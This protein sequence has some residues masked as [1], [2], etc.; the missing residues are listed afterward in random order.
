MSAQIIYGVDF[1]A[2][3]Y[4]KKTIEELA[5]DIASQLS[6]LIGEPVEMIPYHGQGIDGMW[7]DSGD[8]A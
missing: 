4:S 3:T 2:K 1:R 7:P 8:C 6:G 5:A